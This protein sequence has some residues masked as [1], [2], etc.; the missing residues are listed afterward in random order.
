MATN[1][2]VR[3]VALA[4]PETAERPSYG[5][6]PSFRVKGKFFA[7]I[8]EDGETLVVLVNIDQKPV[9]IESAPQK[10]FTT[11]HYDGHG[12]VLVRIAAV[13]RDELRDLLTESWR[14]AAPKR[15]LAAWDAADH[16]SAR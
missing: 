2:A 16:S 11:P 7:R 9:L 4:L 3:E 13:D 12:S 8:R 14:L 10:F 1:E 5:G 15:L 6:S